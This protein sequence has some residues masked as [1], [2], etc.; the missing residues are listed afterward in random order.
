MSEV[1][2]F[3]RARNASVRAGMPMVEYGLSRDEFHRLADELEL[4]PDDLRARKEFREPGVL[5]MFSGVLLVETGGS[6]R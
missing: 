5:G 2:R 4:H 1:E 6:Q 3:F